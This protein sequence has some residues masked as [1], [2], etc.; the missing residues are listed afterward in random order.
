MAPGFGIRLEPRSRLHLA[1]LTALTGVN[2]PIFP[3][4]MRPYRL[5]RS[6]KMQ[7]KIY[8]Y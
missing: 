6:G 4:W 3:V 5:G 8:F 2:L 7:L 1:G